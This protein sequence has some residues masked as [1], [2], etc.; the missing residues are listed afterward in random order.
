M[1]R[2]L[3]VATGSELNDV[4]KNGDDCYWTWNPLDLFFNCY[5]ADLDVSNSYYNGSRDYIDQDSDSAYGDSL[6]VSWYGW[7]WENVPAGV[8]GNGSVQFSRT[9][10]A[11]GT[12]AA[13]SVS[14][15]D[16]F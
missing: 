14:D 6:E 1:R 7:F 13:G 10:F 3:T 2:L 9:Y 4:E 8:C 15:D 16:C 12:D 11:Y 5:K